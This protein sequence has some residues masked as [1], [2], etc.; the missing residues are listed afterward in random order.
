M[1]QLMNVLSFITTIYMMLI[2]VRVAITWFGGNWYGGI[3]EAI[4]RITDPYLNWFRRFSG[5]R[6]GLLDLSPLLAL[7]ILSLLSRVFSFIAGSGAITLGII[8][9]MLLQTIW[10]VVSF[11]LGFFIIVLIL[12]L[13]ALLAGLNTSGFFWHVVETISS[14]VLYRI[15]RIFFKN[16]IAH[17]MSSVIL[18]IL[19][20]GA[21]YVILSI[22]VALGSGLLAGLPV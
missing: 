13:I 6:V 18:S 14:P 3:P 11:F 12:Y 8:L 7:G 16:K 20:L 4:G 15:N 10:G 9:A 2:F 1:H 5:L 21:S 17:F 19:V 22:L